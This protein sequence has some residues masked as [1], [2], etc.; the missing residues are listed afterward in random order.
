MF[1]VFPVFMTSVIIVKSVIL[2]KR[3]AVRDK[4]VS[5]SSR[6]LH[7]QP[8]WQPYPMGIAELDSGL[9]EFNM[10]LERMLK[11]SPIK[12]IIVYPEG[13]PRLTTGVYPPQSSLS[14]LQACPQHPVAEHAARPLSTKLAMS[15][16]SKRRLSW[17]ILCG[18][19]SVLHCAWCRSSDAA[20]L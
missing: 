8:H 20:L 13:N 11:R 9:Q 6:M 18:A 17:C 14:T 3:D 16:A 4:Q 1:W 19:T 7:L 10:F 5:H 2:F 12:S 15:C